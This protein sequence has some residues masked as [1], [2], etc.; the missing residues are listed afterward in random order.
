[1]QL[2]NAFVLVVAPVAIMA[3]K[4]TKST[5]AKAVKF[6]DDLVKYISKYAKPTVQHGLVPGIII[7]G[8]LTT[9]PRPHILQ[10]VT[11]L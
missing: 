11:P 8:L 2:P 5:Q 7:L 3:K 4:K 6:L 9:K 1:M 10:L